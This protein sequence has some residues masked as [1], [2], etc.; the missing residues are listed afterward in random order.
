MQSQQEWRQKK[1][2]TFEIKKG[3]KKK[4]GKQ[5]LIEAEFTK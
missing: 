2:I 1:F 5:A 3:E 4:K